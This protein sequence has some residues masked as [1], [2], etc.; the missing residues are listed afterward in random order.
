MAKTYGRSRV[1][2][3][4][5]RPRHSKRRSVALFIR[6]K[7]VRWHL[8]GL[9]CPGR[10]KSEGFRGG[11]EQIFDKFLSGE[12]NLGLSRLE[13]SDR[14]TGSVPAAPREFTRTAR[15]CDEIE[16]SESPGPLDSRSTFPGDGD[17]NRLMIFIR[18][19]DMARIFQLG[20]HRL[21]ALYPPNGPNTMEAGWGPG[22]RGRERAGMIVRSMPVMS[23]GSK[24]ADP[25]ARLLSCGTGIAD[26]L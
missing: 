25:T 6:P 18:P 1:D 12:M 16:K 19:L 24:V 21:G 15:A 8:N 3:E 11:G 2:V 10:L 9:I 26:F 13:K 5:A 23:T 17:D 22:N 4:I 14:V 20:P 7:D